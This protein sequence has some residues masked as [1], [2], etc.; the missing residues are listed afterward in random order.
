MRCH[1]RPSPTLVIIEL[2][3]HPLRVVESN[4]L[5]RSSLHGRRV[6]ATLSI[7]AMLISCTPLVG[8]A[9]LFVGFSEC[10]SRDTGEW[11]ELEVFLLFNHLYKGLNGQ[12]LCIYSPPCPWLLWTTFFYLLRAVCHVTSFVTTAETPLVSGNHQ[13]PL[14]EEHIEEGG[15][16][17][18]NYIV[19]LNRIYY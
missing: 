8:K 3:Q 4:I 11:P 10:Y 7:K 16:R 2:P 14:L 1:L 5:H 18:R 15:V 12:W 17:M 13:K 19:S 6:G 9:D